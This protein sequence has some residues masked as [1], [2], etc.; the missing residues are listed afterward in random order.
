MCC[1]LLK[2]A[3]CGV[4]WKG[5]LS[6]FLQEYAHDQITTDNGPNKHIKEGLGG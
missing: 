2:A 4:Q 5:L 6:Q 1:L 3:L